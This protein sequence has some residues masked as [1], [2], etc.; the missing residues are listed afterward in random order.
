MKERG[1]LMTEIKFGTDGWRD[2][3]YDRFNLPNVKQVVHAISRYVLAHN[4]AKRGVVVGYDARFFSDFFAAEAGKI[5]NRYGIKVYFGSR[6]Y[7]TPV[8]AFAVKHYGAFGAI[9]FTASHNPPEYNGIKFIPEYAGPATLEITK[10]I[11]NQLAQ[12]G[13]TEPVVAETKVTEG[14]WENINPIAAY[15]QELRKLVDVQKIID[16]GL[17]IVIDPM[18][19]TGRGILAQLLQGAKVTEIRNHRDPLFEGG[20]PDPQ[21]KYLTKLQEAV[22]SRKNAIGLAMD[23]DAD[24][25]GIIDSDGTYLTPNQVISLMLYHLV[26]HHGCKGVAVRSVATTHFIDRLGQRLGIETVETPV[27]FKY[28]GELMRTQPVVVGGE[29]SGGLSVLGHIPEKDGVLAGA[30]MAEL[31][32]VTGKS[33]GE[34]LKQLAA[35]VGESHS[36]RL[37]LRLSEADKGQVLQGFKTTKLEEIG[38]VAIVEKRTL[39]GVKFILANGDWFLV[40]PSGTEPLIRIYFEAAGPQALKE[41]MAAVQQLVDGW[42]GSN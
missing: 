5:L 11:E 30:L 9:M 22:L 29:E 23:G 6:D 34:T 19:A 32:A 21:A 42:K 2:L 40:R 17:E 26:K 39:D 16:S 27:G 24:R 28:I 31:L 38:G 14:I 4:G 13:A 12:L 18:C 7:P 25:F 37:D 33:L 10:E 1:L 15:L 35:E 8:I 3:M 20:M 36:Q 41:L